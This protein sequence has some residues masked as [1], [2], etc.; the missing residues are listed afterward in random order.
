MQPSS[1]QRQEGGVSALPS[2]L[3]GFLKWEGGGVVLRYVWR[4]D[5]ITARVRLLEL[6][7]SVAFTTH[8]TLQVSRGVS[9][10]TSALLVRL[11]KLP[12][13]FAYKLFL[14]L[15]KNL[16]WR[17]AL[18]SAPVGFLDLENSVRTRV[19]YTHLARAP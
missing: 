6:S 9:A 8:I 10:L 16:G 17:G 18:T 3:L 5:L 7:S 2:D 4:G 14:D 1:C 12:S 11:L 19:A 15:F 13:L